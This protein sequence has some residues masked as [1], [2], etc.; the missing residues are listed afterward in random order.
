VEDHGSQAGCAD[1]WHLQ[2]CL[3]LADQRRGVFPAPL[4]IRK[5]RETEGL[6]SPTREAPPFVAQRRFM[7]SGS[8]WKSLFRCVLWSGWAAVAVLWAGCGDWTAAPAPRVFR[9]MCDASAGAWVK[10]GHFVVASDEDNVLRVYDL[11]KPGLPEA[12]LP[13]DSFL[14]VASKHSEAD[15]EGACRVGD[16]I[17]WIASH[18]RNKNGRPRPNRRRFFAVRIS[19]VSGKISLSPAGA[20]CA[21]LLEAIQRLPGLRGFRLDNGRAPKE[22][23]VNIEGLC[24]DGRGGLLIGF[25]SPLRD[26]KALLAPLRNP[27]EA[28]LRGAQPELGPPI[29][30]DLG[31][32]GVRSLLRLREGPILILAGPVSES[33]RFRLYTWDGQGRPEPTPV[34]FGEDLGPEGMLAEARRGPEGP[35]G[36]W[37]LSDDGTRRIGGRRC[38]DLSVPGE[39]RF[40]VFYRELAR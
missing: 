12:Q 17:Y 39:R 26:G 32:L 34:R 8:T 40:R 25:R 14:K 33:G 38:K 31:G 7:V 30:L 21:G 6:P 5:I 22:G 13:L 16:L 24:R 20:P 27:R 37:F 1:S 29:W 2:I 15:I 3:I 35:I 10:P 19:T 18:G 23:G 36:L 11:A 9:G 4:R 28:V